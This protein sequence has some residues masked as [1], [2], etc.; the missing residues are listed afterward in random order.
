MWEEEHGGRIEG[1]KREES[2][3]VCRSITFIFLFFIIY[4][5][6]FCVC[7]A[8][9]RGDHGRV[10]GPMIGAASAF[11]MSG[12]DTLFLQLLKGK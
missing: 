12:R 11:R 5:I 3:K 7:I 10:A 9:V 4:L 1:G 8:V 6:I 2:G